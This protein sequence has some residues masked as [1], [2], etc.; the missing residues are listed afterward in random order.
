MKNYRQYYDSASEDQSDGSLSD[1]DSLND[2]SVSDS[3]GSDS[4]SNDSDYGSFWGRRAE[5]P[6]FST[7][8][9]SLDEQLIKAASQGDVGRVAD[10]IDAGA[11]IHYDRDAALYWAASNGRLR[12]IVYL[13]AVV[14]EHEGKKGVEKLANSYDAYRAAWINRHPDVLNF[15][16]Q[17]GTNVD[18]A[19]TVSSRNRMVPK[20]FDNLLSI[21]GRAFRT[22][23]K[24]YSHPSNADQK[25]I[26]AASEGN[27]KKV[28]EALA[29]G[30]KNSAENYAAL[31]EAR[32]NAHHKVEDYLMRVG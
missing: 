14:A 18:E 17:H 10:L 27:L 20:Y 25:L 5:T 8:K 24:P 3:E 9:L 16:A 30:A 26:N 23:K 31:R 2:N 22:Q 6:V 19:L 29:Q 21:Q 11:N 1:S 13:F 32:A 15:F 4:L 12:V 7:S 28:R